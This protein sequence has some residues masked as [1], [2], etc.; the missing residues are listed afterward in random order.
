VTCS[1]WW[2]WGDS[3]STSLF[4]SIGGQEAVAGATCGFK[5]RPVTAGD[6]RCRGSP[7][8]YGP[9]TDRRSIACYHSAGGVGGSSRLGSED[10][11]GPPVGAST[12]TSP[13]AMVARIVVNESGTGVPL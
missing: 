7:V 4:A 11:A 6:R 3:N 8:G 10:R 13:P 5:E 1:C 12:P 2:R 9:S